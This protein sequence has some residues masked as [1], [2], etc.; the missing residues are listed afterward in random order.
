MKIQQSRNIRENRK[1]DRDNPEGKDV[2][3]KPQKK[4][5]PTQHRILIL[6]R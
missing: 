5:N 4:E 6:E 3:K 2:Q 1:G